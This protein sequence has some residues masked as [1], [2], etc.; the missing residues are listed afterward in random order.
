MAGLTM[1]ILRKEEFKKAMSNRTKAIKKLEGQAIARATRLVEATAKK[2][3]AKEGSFMESMRG[4][5]SHWSSQ[6]GDPP[7]TDTGILIGGITH[8]VKKERGQWIGRVFSGAKYSAWLEFGTKNMAA[9]PFMRP[10]LINNRKKIRGLI[11]T[12]LVKGLDS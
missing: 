11:R 6:P 2:S 1:V 10:A 5:V 4:N 12:A 8:N 9:R 7:A 3:L